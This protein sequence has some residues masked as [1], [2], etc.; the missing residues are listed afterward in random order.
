MSGG[1]SVGRSEVDVHIVRLRGC[2]DI[3]TQPAHDLQMKAPSA[4]VSLGG[5]LLP[6]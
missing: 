1:P 5:E 3:A 2:V 4:S 6:S